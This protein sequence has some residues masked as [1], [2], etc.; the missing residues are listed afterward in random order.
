MRV[1]SGEQKTGGEVRPPAHDGM[2]PIQEISF[3]K[4]DSHFGI[5]DG[6]ARLPL[7][8]FLLCPVRGTIL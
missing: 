5:D 1:R 2:I 8:L 4:F 6:A 3:A 7:F